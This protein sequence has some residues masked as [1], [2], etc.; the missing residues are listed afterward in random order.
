MSKK[1]DIGERIFKLLQERGMSQRELSKLTGI[2]T[3]TISDW[4]TKGNEPTADKIV[5]I[6]QA[7]NV[8]S[9]AIFG[10]V[11]YVCDQRVVSKDEPLWQLIEC[12]DKMDTAEQERL[13]KYMMAII[14]A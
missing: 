11:D 13:L 6:C 2:P 14:N 12:Y 1:T 8:N 9:E 4:K 5:L 7:L 3:S 10:P